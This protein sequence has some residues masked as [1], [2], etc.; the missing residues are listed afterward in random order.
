MQGPPPKKRRIETN[1]EHKYSTIVQNTIF[2][3]TDDFSYYILYYYITF[4]A[5][6]LELDI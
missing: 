3:F 5:V 2:T 6:L 4:T 1:K